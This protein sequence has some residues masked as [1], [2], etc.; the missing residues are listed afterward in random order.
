M[1][2]AT[3]GRG[4]PPASH[5]AWAARCAAYGGHTFDARCCMG[6]TRRNEM[7]RTRGTRATPLQH[8]GGMGRTHGDIMRTRPN[9]CVSRR[10]HA[11][12]HVGKWVVV[13]LE[14]E[15]A[16]H[17]ICVRVC[18]CV[19]ARARACACACARARVRACARARVRACARGRVR[20]RARVCV[21]VCVCVRACVCVCVCVCV[22]A[23]AC[24]RVYDV[25][26]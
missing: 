17:Q 19:C 5:N 22:C 9:I 26:E 21:C 6:A 16:C 23:R 1:S 24:A 12:L 25:C 18:V 11:M 3:L 10:R 7:P 13:P 15:H 4:T 20:A 14:H 8:L 2:G